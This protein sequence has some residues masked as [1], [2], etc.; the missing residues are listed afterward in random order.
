MNLNAICLNCHYL[1]YQL[2]SSVW[3]NAVLE[4][5]KG[6][7]KIVSQHKLRKIL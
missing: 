6:Q 2:K 1:F 4:A 7:E 3:F 5:A